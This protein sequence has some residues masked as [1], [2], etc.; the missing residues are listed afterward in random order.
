MCPICLASAGMMA[1]SMV[2]TGG[3]AALAAKIWRGRK[4]AKLSGLKTESERRGKR[5][6]STVEERGGQGRVAR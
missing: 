3:V 2:S 5:G 4:R 1:G 6:N